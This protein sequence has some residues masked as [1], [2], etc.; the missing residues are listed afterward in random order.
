MNAYA[1][2]F[3]IQNQRKI[4][5]KKKLEQDQLAEE[6]MS[7]PIIIFDGDKEQKNRFAHV[8][9]SRRKDPQTIMI[10]CLLSFIGLSGVHRIVLN[11]IGMGILY[12]L[13]GGICMIGTIVDLINYKSIK[14]T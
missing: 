6:E 7:S 1:R 13:T 12:L 4:A 5:M 8:Y 2:H 11:N 14:A 9:R 3:R 10:L